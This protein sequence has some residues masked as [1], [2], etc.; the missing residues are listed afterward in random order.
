MTP[1]CKPSPGEAEADG[2]LR[3]ADQAHQRNQQALGHSERA[4]LK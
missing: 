2:S 3:P 4:C 1:K